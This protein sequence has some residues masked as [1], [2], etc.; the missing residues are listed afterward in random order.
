MKSKLTESFV[1]TFRTLD[2][3]IQNR[4]RRAYREWRENQKARR[5]KQVGD[6]VS[7]RMDRNYRALGYVANDTVYWYWIGKHD[8]YDRKLGQ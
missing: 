2:P 8:E 4:A 5:F 3:E 1:K 6:D 7:V